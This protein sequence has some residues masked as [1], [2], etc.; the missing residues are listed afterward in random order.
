MKG[1][2]ADLQDHYQARFNY[3]CTERNTINDMMG[4][5]AGRVAAGLRYALFRKGFLT[6]GAG[7]AGGFFKTDPIA[8]DARRAVPFHPVL[9]RRGRAE[10]A[11]LAGLPRLDLP[12]SPREP[13]LRAHQVG[14]SRAGA[15]DPAA[16]HDGAGAIAT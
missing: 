15:R 12:A 10:A 6:I 16:L 5:L 11:S 4:S 1:V 13:R 8:G 2:G 7:Y 14:R 3:R 9:G